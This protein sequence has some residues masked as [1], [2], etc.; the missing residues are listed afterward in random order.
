M[1]R[2]VDSIWTMTIL[3]QKNGGYMKPVL[4][5]RTPEHSLGYLRKVT[6]RL[7]WLRETETIIPGAPSMFACS[8]RDEAQGTVGRCLPRRPQRRLANQAPAYLPVP[9]LESAKVV[10][11]MNHFGTVNEILHPWLKTY[12]TNQL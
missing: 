12:G 2:M 7:G 9:C 3:R 11:G 8:P 4:V 6:T 1:K 5:F 10:M